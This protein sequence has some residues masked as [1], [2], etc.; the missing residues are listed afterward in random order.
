MGCFSIVVTLVTYSRGNLL[1]YQCC[2]RRVLS[3]LL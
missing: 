1:L 3:L 2:R